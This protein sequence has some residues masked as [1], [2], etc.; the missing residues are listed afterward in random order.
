MEV[1]V[2]FES[3]GIELA[4]AFGDSGAEF[5]KGGDEPIDDRLIQQWP[6]MLGGL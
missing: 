4:A 3:G 5:V 6:E 2:R 1:G